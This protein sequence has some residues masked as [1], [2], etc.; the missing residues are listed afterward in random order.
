MYVHHSIETKGMGRKQVISFRFF[1]DNIEDPDA[2][3][4]LGVTQQV[5]CKIKI[6]LKLLNI[7]S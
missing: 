5:R 7:K 1:E 6:T 2:K 3:P 4:A